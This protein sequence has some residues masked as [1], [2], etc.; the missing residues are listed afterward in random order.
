MANEI[1]YKTKIKQIK[2]NKTKE[3]K[4]KAAFAKQNIGKP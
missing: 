4:E 1:R 2:Q 3:K